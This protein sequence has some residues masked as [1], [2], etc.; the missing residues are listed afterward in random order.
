MATRLWSPSDLPKMPVVWFDGSDMATLAI[1]ANGTTTDSWTS[2]G[3]YKVTAATGNGTP[4]EYSPT[5][6]NGKPGLKGGLNGGIALSFPSS[7]IMPYGTMPHGIFVTASDSGSTSG[8]FRPV[9]SWGN[10]SNSQW[11]TLGRNSGNK[12]AGSGWGSSADTVSS[13]NWPTAGGMVDWT[14]DGVNNSTLNLDGT[15]I[16]AK[17]NTG[18]LTTPA[19][20]TCFIAFATTATNQWDDVIQEI[21]VTDY[22]PTQADTARLQGYRAWKWNQVDRLPVGHAYKTAAPTVDDGAAT[23]ITGASA[24]TLAGIGVASA[25]SLA[26]IAATS[27]VLAGV[28]STSTS[29]AP[30]TAQTQAPVGAIV[31]ASASGVAATGSGSAQLQPIAT[32]GAGSLPV[33][34][35][36]ASSL[37]DVASAAAGTLAGSGVVS[38]TLGSVDTVS[39]ARADVRGTATT[40]LDSI[41][42]NASAGGQSLATASS[43]S[44]LDSVA[45][46][47]TGSL[48]AVAIGSFPLATIASNSSTASVVRGAVSG[49][50]GLITSASDARL[51]VRAVGLGS[52]GTLG[53]AGSVISIVMGY[54][55][56]NLGGVSSSASGK[57][58]DH[59]PPIVVPVTRKALLTASGVR[60]IALAN[61]GSRR[62]SI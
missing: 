7:T 6:K 42:G 29:S 49:S 17:S 32:V 11:R 12:I 35:V 33:R 16:F 36:S 13:T 43:A 14:Q 34:G 23:V 9:I 51:T 55:S 1:R 62:L 27:L 47:S 24:S 31:S 46:T 18:N 26:I 50:L 61:I 22:V 44:V 5:A 30:I 2:K 52:L 39:A 53:F 15:Q 41:V 57:A 19:N 20:T 4:L 8:L 48:P 59:A 3:S 58:Q 25:A 21:I 40:T 10:A 54:A 28:A 37:G 38:T 45:T 56:A 60:R